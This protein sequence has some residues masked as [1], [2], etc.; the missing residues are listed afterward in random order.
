[1]K[2]NDKALDRESTMDNEIKRR[3][4][5]MEGDEMRRYTEK[6]EEVLL[7]NAHKILL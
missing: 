7:I 6:R 5:G 2:L 4:G 1:M 3:Y